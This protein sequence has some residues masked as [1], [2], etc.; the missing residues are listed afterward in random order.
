M[1]LTSH[2]VVSPQVESPSRYESFQ[3]RHG[4]RLWVV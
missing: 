1:R 4:E 2:E 3:I